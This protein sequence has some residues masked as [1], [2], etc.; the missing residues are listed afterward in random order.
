[1]ADINA[2]YC[3]L[4]AADE[5]RD[6]AALTA[7]AWQ[8]YGELATAAADLGALRA[9]F[10]VFAA[11][12]HVSGRRPTPRGAQTDACR[13]CVAGR[14]PPVEMSVQ[15]RN[16]SHGCWP[17]QDNDRLPAAGLAALLTVASLGPDL[18]CTD[19][20]ELFFAES[21]DDVQRAKDLC[22]ECPARSACLAAALKRQEPWG[23]WGGELFLRGAIVPR[24]PA[25]G[26]PRKTDV[27]A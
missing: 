8:V 6:A 9:G 1:M 17:R 15:V 13:G 12:P 3:S 25:R 24:K 11:A 18:P 14:R 16:E 5:A 20:P 21:P 19:D 2:L 10:R 26:R 4:L 27:A 23:V 22:R 7:V